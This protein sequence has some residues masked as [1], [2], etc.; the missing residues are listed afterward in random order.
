MKI[1]RAHVEVVSDRGARLG[2]LV[3]RLKRCFAVSC[4]ILASLPPLGAVGQIR[5]SLPANALL[6][7]APQALASVRSSTILR[8]FLSSTTTP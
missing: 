2:I 6:A 7:G 3:T 1:D 4:F 5:E 8:C